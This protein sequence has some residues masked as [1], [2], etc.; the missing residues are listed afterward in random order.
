M[1]YC[2]VKKMKSN[3]MIKKIPPVLLSM[4]IVLLTSCS[5]DLPTRFYALDAVLVNK[6]DAIADTGKTKSIGIGPV[7]LPALLNRKG[8]VTR[9]VQS[10]IDIAET[11]QWAEP[12]LDNV[13]R[14]ITRNLAT[15]QPNDIVYAYPWSLL[16]AVEYRVVIN[17]LQFDAK[18]GD[19]VVFEAVWSIKQEQKQQVSK[20]GHSRISH[21]IKTKDYA[22]MVEVMNQILAEFS[23]EL[24]EDL[25]KI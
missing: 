2:G 23:A 10:G 1:P 22:A 20:R 25:L 15:L 11:D 12:L 3:V 17:I 8:I 24:S 16:D 19:S 13:T 18:L 7:A 4:V 9:L 21:P 5:S 14:V 6:V